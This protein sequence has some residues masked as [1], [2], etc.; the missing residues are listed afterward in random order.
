MPVRMLQVRGLGRDFGHS[1]GGARV[2]RIPSRAPGSVRAPGH[3]AG[4]NDSTP[5]NYVL[6]GA[7][8]VNA[9]IL[10]PTVI[11]HQLPPLPPRG[12][13]Y[14]VLTTPWCLDK[15]CNVCPITPQ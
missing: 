13:W 4:E 6:C 7:H 11:E 14:V 2:D 12:L 9:V 3:R 5:I 1:A 10:T 8:I 15:V